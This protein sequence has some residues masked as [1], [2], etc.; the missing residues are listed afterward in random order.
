MRTVG[1]SQCPLG[2]GPINGLNRKTLD[3]KVKKRNGIQIHRRRMGKTRRILRRRAHA[4]TLNR[5]AT[6]THHN[7]HRKTHTPRPR[8]KTR[9][10]SQTRLRH[11]P[12][13]R[14]KR[15]HAKAK[16]KIGKTPQTHGS[17]KIQTR[18]KPTPNS[19]RTHRQK[20]PEPRSPKQLLGRRRRTTQ[21]VRNHTARP[22]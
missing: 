4:P 3:K 9:L 1:G 15:R 7:T 17:Q 20:I 12:N 8:Q 5:M 14:K 2:C 10:Q 19:R 13:P 6:T 18:Q 22:K 11:S 21:M 16:T